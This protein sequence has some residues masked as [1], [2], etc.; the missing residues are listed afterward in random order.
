MNSS[1]KATSWLARFVPLAVVVFSTGVGSLRAQLISENFTSGAANFTVVSGGTWAVTSGKYVLTNPVQ[2]AAGSGNGNIAT[3]NTSVSGDWTLTVDASTTATSSVWNDVSVIFN[4]QDASNYHYV[5]FNESND[6]GTSGIFKF[7]AGVQTQLTD[8][9]SLITGGSI[10]AVQIMKTGNSYQVS[11]NGTLVASVTDSTFNSGKVGFGTLND[12]ASFDNLV[13]TAAGGGGQVA[14]PSFSPV[15]GNYTSAQS[16]TITTA[17]SG[18]TI[19]YTTDGSTPTSTSGT[20]YSSPVSIAATATLKAIAYKSGMSDSTVTSDTYTINTGG[21]GGTFTFYPSDDAYLQ[22][23]TRNNTA[24]LR[25]QA[26]S[27]SRIT[28]LKFVVSGLTGTVSSV[29]LR[30]KCID[31][32]SGTLRVKTGN[33]NA[34]TE[35]TLSTSNAPTSIGEVGNRS[36]SWSSGTTY[37]LALTGALTADGTY[38]FI[39]DQDNVAG[40][41]DVWFNSKDASVPNAEKPQLIVTTTGSGGGTVAA[42]SFSPV[43]GT[44]SSAQSVTISS[45]TSG[46]SI[47]YTT[48]GSTPT[49]TTGTVYSAPVSIGATTTL[50]AIAYKSGMTDSSVTSGTYTINLPAVA[51]PTFNPIAGTYSSAQSVTISSTTSGAS[52]RYTTNGTNPT[53]TTG[54]VYFTPVSI[55]ATTTLKAI[56]YKS[57]MSD[58][59]VTTGTYTITTPDTQAPTAPTNLAGVAVS[60][61]QI[62]LGWTASTDNVGVTNY[63]VYRNGAPVGTPT[64]TTFNDTGLSASTAYSYT[65]KAED[66]AHNLSPASNA[67]NITT[68]SN[69]GT[70][71]RVPSYGANGTHWPSLVPTPFMYDGSVPNVINVACSWSAIATAISSVTSTQAAAGVLIKIAPG[72]LAGNGSSSGS[73]PVLE[74]LGSTSWSKRVTVCPRDGYG[75]VTFSGGVRILKVF[76]VCFA[77]F[78]GDDWKLQ[79]CTRSALAWTKITGWYSGY[80]TSGQATTQV[81]FV[82]VVQPD[83]YVVNQDASDFY[84]GGGDISGWRFEGCYSAPRF[85]EDPPPD[86]KPHTDTFQFAATQGGNYGSMA[87]RDCAYYSSNNCSI[88]TGNVNGASFEH[89]Y[90]VS[91]AVSRARYPWLPG[92]STEATTN[93]FNGSGQNFTAVDSVFIGGMAINTSDAPRPWSSVTN[94][95]TDR[96]YGASNQPLSGAWTVDTT[97]SATNPAMPPYPTDSYLNSIWQ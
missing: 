1:P 89:T 84:T 63:V 32:G 82:E 55:A 53:S 64:G 61:S 44:Y 85:F 94:T 47:R 86:P 77:G 97:L 17:T 4:Y 20:I 83:H 75:T 40:F 5:S 72:N 7:V 25:V 36:G 16:V 11:R 21:G 3:H 90:V 39:V 26:T 46:A 66:A 95:K 73:T 50:K 57:G 88:Q 67:I 71:V 38:S 28:Y 54:T 29:V 70:P 78:K 42:P 58:S 92:G 80:G 33:S 30:A 24:D 34:W 2:G 65:V 48:D 31:S 96:T 9:T 74:N 23:S 56:A 6:G 60:S 59:S 51:A 49:S 41:N 91:G 81:E 8:I 45:T 18:A 68:L 13:V 10:Y 27:T 79:G 52:I 35:T 12:G 22:G 37:D 76:G 19:R 87:F 69:S 43:A 15:G 62:N 93:A 14:A